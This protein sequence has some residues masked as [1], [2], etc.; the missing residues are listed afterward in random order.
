MLLSF[1]EHTA[2]V[3]PRIYC[4]CLSD[5]ILWLFF[6]ED[7]SVVFHINTV[8]VSQRIYWIYYRCLSEDILYSI[9]LSHIEDRAVVSQIKYFICLSE[10]IL[11]L[12]LREQYTLQCLLENIQSFGEKRICLSE[13]IGT[14]KLSE[15][16]F[17]SFLSDKILYFSL[18]AQSV[19]VSHRTCCSCL[20]ENTLQL[21]LWGH[22]LF[23][24]E[25]YYIFLSENRIYCSYL[26]E[27]TL[28]SSFRENMNLPLR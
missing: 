17:C 11:Y 25:H 27:S 18:K 5:S 19:V 14:V 1:R 22:T 9:C 16:M 21:S 2:V 28:Q 4:S 20:T 7:H 8:F 23:L 10:N 3:P 12:S 6:R 13:N 24:G 26:S 15:Q